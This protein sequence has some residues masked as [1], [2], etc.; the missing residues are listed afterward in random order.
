MNGALPNHLNSAAGGGG[1]F[2]MW[3]GVDMNATAFGNVGAGGMSGA[4]LS[5]SMGL[6]EPSSAWFIPFN[7]NPPQIADGASSLYM[8]AVG[9]VDGG[10]GGSFSEQDLGDAGMAD[11]HNPG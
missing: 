10:G 4:G 3:D 7:M 5:W 9:A 1:Q 2:G 11:G 8:G 6:Q